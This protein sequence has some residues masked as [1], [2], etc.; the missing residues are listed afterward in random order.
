MENFSENTNKSK[1][2]LEEITEKVETQDLSTDEL[3]SLL[4]EAVEVGM[5]VCAQAQ[6]NIDEQ[7]SRGSNEQN[8]QN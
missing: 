1:T 2:R 8:E 6:S 3:L 4:E 7:M 5:D